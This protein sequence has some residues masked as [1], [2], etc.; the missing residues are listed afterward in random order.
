M[1]LRYIMK[2]K[3]IKELEEI[4]RKKTGE[5]KLP[6]GLDVKI[7]KKPFNVNKFLKLAKEMRRIF[8]EDERHTNPAF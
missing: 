7:N 6:I 5:D 4:L 8:D 1:S 3:N 2:N